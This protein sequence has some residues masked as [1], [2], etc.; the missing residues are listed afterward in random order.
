MRRD[1][2]GTEREERRRK[3][4][5]EFIDF[6][7]IE[8]NFTHTDFLETGTGCYQEASMPKSARF[9]EWFRKRRRKR[10]LKIMGGS[11]L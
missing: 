11:F 8:L 3:E 9:Y 7:V 6:I 5:L 4:F 1:Y 2:N 10:T